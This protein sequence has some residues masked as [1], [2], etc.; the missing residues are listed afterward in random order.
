MCVYRL[1]SFL[2]ICIAYKTLLIILVTITYVDRSLK[3]K[4][5]NILL[6]VDYVTIQ[7]KK[8]DY[9]KIKIK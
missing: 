4:I 6:K 3:T 1:G 8:I 5:G 9:V 7:K 2:N